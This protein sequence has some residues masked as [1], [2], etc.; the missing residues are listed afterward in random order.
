MS[1][2]QDLPEPPARAEKPQVRSV[3]KS[4]ENNDIA[5]LLRGNNHLFR[6][7]N[8]KTEQDAPSK[9]KSG[10]ISKKLFS[11]REFP[12]KKERRGHH[13]RVKNLDLA[14][15]NRGALAQ[16]PRRKSSRSKTPG[17]MPYPIRTDR[18]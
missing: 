14:Q 1:D 17:K 10:Q 13:K 8:S 4:Q 9:K 3:F 5:S 18:F 15:L 6:T 11:G 12:P 16:K 7:M 2:D